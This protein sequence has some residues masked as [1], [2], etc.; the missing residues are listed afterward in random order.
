MF[1]NAMADDEEEEVKIYI[2][3]DFWLSTT[4]SK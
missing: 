4:I 3:S 1:M 2:N